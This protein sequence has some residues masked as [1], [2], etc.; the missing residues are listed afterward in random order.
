MDELFSRQI[1]D[2]FCEG[3]PVSE[4]LLYKAA[5]SLSLDPEDIIREAHYYQVLDSYLDRGGEMVESEKAYLSK[6]AGSHYGLLR[7]T[8]ST[9]GASEEELIL[10]TLFN[11]NFVPDMNKLAEMDSGQPQ[12][13]NIQQSPEYRQLLQN[14]PDIIG[15][16]VEQ[17]NNGQLLSKPT[18]SS[19]SQLPPS[20]NGNYEELLYNDANKEMLEQQEEEKQRQQMMQ[21]TQQQP[22]QGSPE[23]IQ[24]L[25][26]QMSSQERVTHAAPYLSPEQQQVVAQH[27]DQIEQQSGLKLNQLDQ[28]KKVV[29]EM[30]KLQKKMIDESIK[31]HFEQQQPQTGPA[32]MNQTGPLPLRL[33][34]SESQGNI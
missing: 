16:M 6:A 33:Q 28:I 19:P 3:K 30:E 1:F 7:K 29:Q 24:F 23:E 17:G 8:A 26:N 27:I 21:Q 20:Q 32:Q 14:N 22:Q 18:P 34:N 13:G 10:R 15:Q 25:Y 11:N 5:E 2:L 31:Q 9:Y 12:E 4:R